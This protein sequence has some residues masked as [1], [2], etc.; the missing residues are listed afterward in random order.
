MKMG[1]GMAAATV[2]TALQRL[3]DMEAPEAEVA[4]TRCCGS[5]RWV[6]TM[7]ASRPYAS[8]EQLLS[9]AES[10]ASKLDRVDWLEAF[11]HHPKIGDIDSLRARFPKT[12]EWSSSEQSGV[13]AAPEQ[14]LKDLAE[15]NQQYEQRFGY[16]FIVCATGKT[17][18]EMLD[19]LRQRLPNSPEAE[20]PIAAGEQKKIT[21]IRLE[22]LL[23]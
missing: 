21:K 10:A 11:S 8:R 22:K 13:N 9:L 7:L 12:H 15:G 16:I 1:M 2:D 3:N 19:L 4:L 6:Q 18:P 14:V 17:A 23:A 5:K 20:L